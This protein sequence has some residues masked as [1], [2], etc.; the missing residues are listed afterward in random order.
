[1]CILFQVLFLILGYYKI[2]NTVLFYTVGPCCFTCFVYSSLYLLTPDLLISPSLH[3]LCTLVT[4]SFFS[5]PV[6]LFLF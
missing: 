2:M 1:M 4:I 5:V 3:P 6:S